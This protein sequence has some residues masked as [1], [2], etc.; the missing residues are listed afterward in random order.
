M[1]KKII[2][3]LKKFRSVLHKWLIDNIII[4]KLKQREEKNSKGFVTNSIEGFSA[5]ILSKEEDKHSILLKEAINEDNIF[6]IALSGPY[7]SG[8]TSIIK[9]FKH[10]YNLNYIDISLATFDDKFIKE[11]NTLKLEYC[12]L[13]QLF[14]KVHPDKVP[15]SRFKRIVNHQHI[16]LKAFLFF[17]WLTSILYFTNNKILTALIEALSLDFYSTFFNFIYSSVTLIGSIFIVYKIYDFFIN[18]KMTKFKFNE[19][20]LESKQDKATLNFENEIDEILYFFERNPID[21]VFIEDL[22]RFNNTEIFIK[23]REINFLIN[24]YEPIKERGKVTFVYAVIDDIFTQN[25]RTKFF[26]FIVP[27]VPIINYTNSSKELIDRFQN[28]IDLIENEKE[29]REFK[30]FIEKVSLYLIDMRVIISIAN[31]YKVYKNIL[32]EDIDK[33]K[34]FAMMVYKNIEPT[35]FDLLDKREG[36]AYGLLKNKKEFNESSI[37]L[38]QADIEKIQEQ[39]ELANKEILTNTTELRSV[40]LAK[41]LEI[42]SRK[43]N[44]GVSNVILS[45]VRLNLSDLLTDENFN[46]FTQINTIT[47]YYYPGHSDSIPLPFSEIEKSVNPII[48]YSK[49]L[50]N[51]KNKI[52]KQNEELKIKAEGYQNKI[53]DLNSKSLS[54]L[55]NEFDDNDYFEKRQ[56]AYEA[57]LIKKDDVDKKVKNFDLINFLIKSGYIDEDFEHYISR[58]DGNLSKEDRNF[59]LSFNSKALSFDTK[60]KE[61]SSL[62]DKI[63]DVYYY[64]KEILNFSLMDYLIEKN[65]IVEINKIM[66]VLAKE[67]E[68][69][70][71]F[72][73][74]YLQYANDNNKKVFI[75]KISNAWRNIFNFLYNKSNFSFEKKATYIRLIFANQPIQKIK[76]LNLENSISHF[77]SY[78]ENLSPIY[79]EDANKTKVEKLLKELRIDFDRLVYNEAHFDLLKFIYENNLYVI[80]Y[81]MIKMMITTFKSNDIDLEKLN[82]SNYSIIKSSGCNELIKYIDKEIEYY[83]ENVLLELEDNIDESEQNVLHILNDQKVSEDLKIKVIIKNKTLIS[84]LTNIKEKNL[85]KELFNNNKIKISW[86]NLF[87]YFKEFKVIDSILINYLNQNQVFEILSKENISENEN[88]IETDFIIK[89]ILSDISIESFDAL[90]VI[91]PNEYDFSEVEEVEEDK[92]EILIKNYIIPF[93]VENFTGINS[94]HKDLITIF[95]ELNKVEF[96]EELTDLVLTGSNIIYLLESKVFSAEE[97]LNIIETIEE[98]LIIENRKLKSLVCEFLITQSV[99][100]ISDELINSLLKSDASQS[101]RISLFNKYYNSSISINMLNNRLSSLGNPFDDLVNGRDTIKLLDTEENNQFHRL[102]HR[103]ILGE[104]KEKNGNLKIWPLLNKK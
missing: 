18:F 16:R 30:N 93:S 24:N 1:I 15:E 38:L 31:E 102:L 6:N 54:E 85:W 42:V 57:E 37:T 65:K 3:Q 29:K 26:D 84:D 55:L 32:N 71:K 45:A 64:K 25:E 41:F 8:K 39:I 61:F 82:F 70:V 90:A 10:K 67:T 101:A 34:L 44:H 62:L 77:L 48:T 9:T 50:E 83:L 94:I 19:A 69:S 97:K 33:K 4:L 11:G 35:D 87:D 21:V 13:K 86:Q 104:K 52:I 78:L 51:I 46:A 98:N 40:Y 20:E 49:R 60:L 5:K 74:E 80:N 95:S 96:F 103:R 12:I 28:E 36:Y 79:F 23:L 43:K 7:G 92:I 47:Y 56:L 100:T 75:V 2:I 72:I 89:L 68:V 14:Y 88:I 53:K 91:F 73:D 27:V 63:D 59:L 58:Q 17:C 66:N 22:D 99:I 81:S 76:E